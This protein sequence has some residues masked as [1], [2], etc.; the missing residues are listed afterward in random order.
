MG[1]SAFGVILN[2]NQ[3]VTIYL[4]GEDDADD[5]RKTQSYDTFAAAIA[6]G[7]VVD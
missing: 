3:P 4:R 6:D 7:W 2:S 5:Y 1:Y